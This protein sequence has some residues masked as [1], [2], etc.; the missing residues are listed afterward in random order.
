[1]ILKP[2][3]DAFGGIPL[4]GCFSRSASQTVCPSPIA[5]SGDSTTP[6]T[7][8]VT[9]KLP[10]G[11]FLWK[12]RKCSSFI[13]FLVMNESWKL[14]VLRVVRTRSSYSPASQRFSWREICL[15]MSE[16]EVMPLTLCK[17]TS[18]KTISFSE[19]FFKRRKL[20]CQNLDEPFPYTAVWNF[21]QGGR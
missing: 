21:V 18:T 7:L 2:W 19:T 16:Y 10:L 14:R 12:A 11:T 4:S 17:I 5:S 15:R 3:E 20:G 1:M 9:L 8:L 6:P 13:L